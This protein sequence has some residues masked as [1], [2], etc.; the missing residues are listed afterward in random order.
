MN[1]LEILGVS[2]LGLVSLAI[3]VTVYDMVRIL[4]VDFNQYRK[5]P[6]MPSVEYYVCNQCYATNYFKKSKETPST[7]GGDNE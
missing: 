6:E 1:L 4:I 7:I 5:S 2:F 3:A